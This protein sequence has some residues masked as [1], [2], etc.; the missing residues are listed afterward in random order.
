MLEVQNL[1]TYYDDFKVLNDVSISIES[2]NFVSIIGPNGHGKSTLLKT[3]C[4]LLRPKSGIIRFNDKIISNLPAHLLV[5]IGI[6]Y[7]AEKRHLFPEMTV[8]ENL[9]LGAYSSHSRKM[10]KEN[11]NYVFDLFPKLKIRKK[12]LASNLSGG[13]ARMLAIGRGLMSSAKFLA[14]DEPSLGLAPN[15]RVEVFNKIN[16]INKNGITILL[17]E[18]TITEAAKYIDK[19]YLLEDGSITFEGTTEDALSNNHIKKAFLGL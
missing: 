6:V 12:Q 3:I 10:E 4:G 9:Q 2:G 5:D 15:L 1:Y 14:I 11:L 17:V 19:V 7:V 8:F 18:Q 13:E 16:E